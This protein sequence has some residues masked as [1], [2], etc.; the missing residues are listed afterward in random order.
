MEGK[1]DLATVKPVV[2]GGTQGFKGHARVI[3]ASSK[4]ISVLLLQS[5]MRRA[6]RTWRR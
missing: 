2:D 1:P 5:T 6:S 4:S 3:F